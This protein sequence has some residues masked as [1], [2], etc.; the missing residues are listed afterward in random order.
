MI[1]EIDLGKAIMIGNVVESFGHEDELLVRCEI[2][3]EGETVGTYET[4]D[5]GGSPEFDFVSDEA[6]D[7]FNEVTKE[8][9]N[10][11]DWYMRGLATMH[12]LVSEYLDEKYGR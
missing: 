8:L 7:R 12:T 3:I 9:V 10:D 5:W 11:S 2:L 6:H 4:L 1:G